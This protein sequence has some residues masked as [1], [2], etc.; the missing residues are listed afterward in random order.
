MCIRDRLDALTDTQLNTSNLQTDQLLQYNGS[1]WVNATVSLGGGDPTIRTDNGGAWHYLTYVDSNTDNLSQPLKMDTGLMYYPS[2]NWLRAD[3]INC[4]RLYD[5][6]NSAGSTG[7]FL[8]SQGTSSN[9]KWTSSI[10]DSKSA[11]TNGGIEI[12]SDGELLIKKAGSTSGSG[13]LEGGH[14]QFMSRDNSTKNY[15]IDVYSNNGT[16]DKA[17]IRVIDQTVNKQRFCVNRHGAWG[18][19]HTAPDYGSTGQVMISQG[20]TLPPVWGNHGSISGSAFASTA[21]GATADTANSDI[22]DIY[23]QL[24][25]IGNDASITTVAQIKAALAALV[26]G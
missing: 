9:W 19:G 10:I 2:S 21:Q 24:N 25:A 3:V 23:T 13:T 17:V 4:A 12:E 8:I 15:A 26:R 16:E 7:Q 14:I 20:E 11:S 1:K 6:G 18:V 22:D 5:W